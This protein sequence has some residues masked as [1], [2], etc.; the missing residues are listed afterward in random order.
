MTASRC[1]LFWACACACECACARACAI[2]LCMLFELGGVAQAF[3]YHIYCE[4]QNSTG[5]ITCGR[6]CERR[7]AF[8]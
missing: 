7:A 1:G 2:R 8:W 6:R 5:D 3:A 4:N